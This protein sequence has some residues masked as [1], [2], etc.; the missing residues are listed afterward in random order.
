M[1]TD[2]SYNFKGEV[3]TSA[4][5]GVRYMTPIGPFKLDVGFNINDPSQYGISFQIGQ[6]F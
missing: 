2:E 1:L 3:I 6:S 5:A 4:G